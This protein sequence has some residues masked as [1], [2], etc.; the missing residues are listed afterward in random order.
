MGGSSR[1]VVAKNVGNSIT[2]SCELSEVV[3][4]LTKGDLVVRPREVRGGWY[5][6]TATRGARVG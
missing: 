2:N 4:T 5:V 6:D 3:G 1:R